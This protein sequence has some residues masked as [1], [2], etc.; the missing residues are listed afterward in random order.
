[1][2]YT[3]TEANIKAWENQ[4]KKFENMTDVN[5]SYFEVFRDSKYPD[6]QTDSKQKASWL[7][8][9]SRVGNFLDSIAKDVVTMTYE[10][11]AKYIEAKPN[12]K[13]HINGFLLFIIRENVLNCRERIN[14]DLLFWV[15]GF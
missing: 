7:Q 8:Y 15:L 5:N 2:S 14:K 12:T 6:W 3:V 10:E 1:M 9:K 4:I 11:I 13:N